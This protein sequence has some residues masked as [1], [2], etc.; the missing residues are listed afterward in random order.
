MWALTSLGGPTDVF[1][2][3]TMRARSA[4]PGTSHMYIISHNKFYFTPVVLGSVQHLQGGW[5][6]ALPF[7]VC[8]HHGH[9]HQFTSKTKSKEKRSDL[10]VSGEMPSGRKA[11]SARQ[12][13]HLPVSQAEPAG[14][15]LEHG[16]RGRGLR[17]RRVPGS[18]PRV[19]A[20]ARGRAR[21]NCWVETPR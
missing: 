19:G 9:E 6:L 2:V 3:Q 15:P 4:C 7:G 13:Q 21:P 5:S 20:P 18:E 16:A 1:I 10:S 12:T 11:G 8:A 17:A 14:A